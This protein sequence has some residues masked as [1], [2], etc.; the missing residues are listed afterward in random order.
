MLGD[1]DPDTKAAGS[2]MSTEI[3]YLDLDL[4][5]L[6]SVRKCAADFVAQE[7]RLDILYLSAGIIRVAPGVTVEDYEI[8]FGINY[9]G[10]TLLIRLLV[11]TMLHTTQRQP[12]VR[13]V[14]VSSE[15]HVIAPKGGI[16]FNNLKTDGAD[17]VSYS[18]LVSG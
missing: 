14:I 9:L 10:H 13:I 12:D 17:I 18:P 4:S 5:S 8:H 11:P 7:P 15:G 2:P 6:E 1:P 16:D 3:R